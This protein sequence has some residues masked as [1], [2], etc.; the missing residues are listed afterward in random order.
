LII[1]D[2]LGV[3]LEKIGWRSLKT[4]NIEGEEIER[5]HSFLNIKSGSGTSYFIQSVPTP[6]IQFDRSAEKP[7]LKITTF[8]PGSNQDKEEYLEIKNCDTKEIDLYG[9]KILGDKKAYYF[10]KSEILL[11]N[12][13]FRLFSK[14][15]GINLN[16]DKQTIKLADIYNDIIDQTTY[17]PLKEGQISPVKENNNHPKIGPNEGKISEEK[18]KPLGTKVMIRG[19]VMTKPGELSE[20]YFYLQDQTGGIQI[21]SY[22]GRFPSLQRG[23]ELQVYGELSAINGERRIKIESAEGIKVISQ[24]RP[25]PAI[26]VKI[27]EINS[28]QEGSFVTTK[29]KVVGKS[30]DAMILAESD[31]E[32]KILRRNKKVNFGK[33][34]KGDF[35]AI[36]GILSSYKGTF[37][38]LPRDNEDVTILSS[39]TLPEAG[40]GDILKYFLPSGVYILCI[41]FQKTKKIQKHWLDK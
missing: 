40:P 31:T 10:K 21:Y 37:R 14:T 39:R 5:G 27:N 12:Q 18:V 7:N 13:S 17:D 25:A 8:S 2:S 26:A 35:I 29:G 19:I 22:Y 16:K 28:S 3:E 6:G 30:T 33:I 38:I 9:F 20:K 23:D 15:I 4:E 34:K 1:K 36:S 32:I 41:I 11:P 24:Q